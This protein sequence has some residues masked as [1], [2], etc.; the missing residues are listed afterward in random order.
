LKMEVI[1]AGYNIDAVIIE[2]M[3][4][5]LEKIKD[6][7]EVGDDELRKLVEELASEKGELDK[8]AITPEVIS[9]AYARISR[10]GDPVTTLR[11]KARKNVSSARGSAK[12]IIFDMN[13]QSVAEHAMFN[14]DILGISRL[15]VEALE[16]HR[17]CSY[18]EKS[19]RYQRLDGSYHLPKEFE[20]EGT[21]LFDETMRSQF[22]CY[23][24]IFPILLEY[25]K[26]VNPGMFEKKPDLRVVEGWAKEDAR[27]A[28]GLATEAQLGFTANARN[29]EYMIRKLRASPLAEVRKL[30]EHFYEKAGDVAPSLILLTDP[31]EYRKEFGREL[32]EDHFMQT[33]PHTKKV[34]KEIIDSHGEHLGEVSDDCVKLLG[35]TED[36]DVNVMASILHSHS[37]EPIERCWQIAESLYEDMDTRLIKEMLRYSNPWEAAT[38]AQFTF[39][40][41]LS[42]ACYG[43]MKRHRLSTQLLQ[44]YDPTLGCTFPPSVIETDL[45]GELEDT[46]KVSE[47]AYYELYKI[48]PVAAQYILT[49]GHRRRMLVIANPRELYHMSRLRE[50]AHAQ[51]DIRDITSKMLKLSKEHAP[52]TLMLAFGKD[53]FDKEKEKLFRS[54]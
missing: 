41:T 48:N 33:H 19:Q 51:W 50:D 25:Q 37:N 27:Y 1:L 42:S 4:R 30:A 18:T 54:I 49:N 29:L 46:F 7:S 15:A 9:A 3:K 5:L 47:E 28:L 34:V 32:N 36:A 2:K 10:S 38:R 52:L 8:E 39:E 53:E 23:E 45:K 22:E 43:Q 6:P 26:K 35:P 11:E 21:K 31:D 13:H 24:K 14:F 44:D 16:W 12:R 20:K 17:L 40:V